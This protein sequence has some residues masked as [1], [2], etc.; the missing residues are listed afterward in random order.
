MQKDKRGVSPVIATVLLILIVLIS[1]L[2]VFMWARGFVAEAISKNQKPAE[3]ACSELSFEAQKIS[4]NTIQVSNKGNIPIYRFEIK[5]TS[6][7][8][9][10]VE[11]TQQTLDIGGAIEITLSKTYEKIEVVP[12]ILGKAG[13]VKKAYTCINNGKII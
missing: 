13:N 4:G 8:K 7:G 5:G 12:V 10:E 9:V 1:A 3:Q 6:T 2:I 11:Q